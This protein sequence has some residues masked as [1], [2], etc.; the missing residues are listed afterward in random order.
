MSTD[1]VAAAQFNFTLTTAASNLQDL[2]LTLVSEAP[3][4]VA[5]FV[6]LYNFQTGQWD[7]QSGSTYM[8]GSDQTLNIDINT[9][10][11]VGPGNQVEVINRGVQ[12]TRYGTTP[13][14]LNTDQAVLVET[15]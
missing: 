12:P 11:Y 1:L 6:Y 14:R 5:Q 8:N 2:N 7:T 9:S 3:S 13:F 10:K 15:Y 4:P